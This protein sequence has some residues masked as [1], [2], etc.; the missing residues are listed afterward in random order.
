MCI[1]AY[2][3]FL[4]ISRICFVPSLSLFTGNCCGP[5]TMIKHSIIKNNK[6]SGLKEIKYKNLVVAHSLEV[7]GRVGMG[8]AREGDRVWCQVTY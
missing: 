5:K 6:V 4:N 8:G 1:S 7:R 3:L 2:I